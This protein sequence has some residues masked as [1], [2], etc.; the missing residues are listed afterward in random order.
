MIASFGKS[1]ILGPIKRWAL[2][3]HD[4]PKISIESIFELKSR[5][6]VMISKIIVSY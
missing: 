4:V 5:F 3:G 2:L 6:L 1:E